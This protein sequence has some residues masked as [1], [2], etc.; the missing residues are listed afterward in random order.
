MR[1]RLS[2]QLFACPHE[3]GRSTLAAPLFHNLFSIFRQKPIPEVCDDGVFLELDGYYL[4]FV[5]TGY[6][7]GLQ[8]DGLF[9][10][11]GSS[12]GSFSQV[13]S[14]LILGAGDQLH[15]EALE[16]RNEASDLGEIP[17]HLVALDLVNSPT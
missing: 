6:E 11:F 7:Q 1:E 2:Q 8:I 3:I 9:Q 10:V 12:R 16:G 5:N 13:V 17:H 14:T 15:H 4:W